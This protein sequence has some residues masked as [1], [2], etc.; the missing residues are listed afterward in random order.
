[1]AGR[2]IQQV[3][4]TGKASSKNMPKRGRSPN[5][6]EPGALKKNKSNQRNAPKQQRSRSKNAPANNPGA[7]NRRNPESPGQAGEKT[8]IP[9]TKAQTNLHRRHKANLLGIYPTLLA[10]KNRQRSNS[11][12]TNHPIWIRW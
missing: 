6:E 11:E 7:K 8:A 9:S 12:E 5:H 3:G 1:M 2:Q 4:T 10:R